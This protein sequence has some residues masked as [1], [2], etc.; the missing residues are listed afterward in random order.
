MRMRGTCDEDEEELGE[1]ESMNMRNKR[2]L[3]STKRLSDSTYKRAMNQAYQ[4]A[5]PSRKAAYRGAIISGGIGLLLLT[6][7][8]VVLGLGQ[9]G[10]GL[11]LLGPG[12]V[13]AGINVWNVHRISSKG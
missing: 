5:H 1:G 11:S 4:A 6:V 9:T 8:G 2:L 12:I 7:G 13:V 10:W 3:E